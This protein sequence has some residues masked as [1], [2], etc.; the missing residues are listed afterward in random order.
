VTEAGESRGYTARGPVDG[1]SWPAVAAALNA[2]MAER[3]IG[4]KVLSE[5]SGVSVATLRQLQRGTSGRRVQNP[6]L[7]AIARA[8]DWPENHLIDV[9][10]S[11]SASPPAPPVGLFACDPE[12]GDRLAVLDRRMDAL[13][14][15]LADL[16][17]VFDG[18]TRRL[19][20]IG[21]PGTSRHRP[22]PDMTTAPDP[23]G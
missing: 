3:R 14:A 1:E 20:Q 23:E 7:Q 19:D 18:L 11:R 6:T 4:Q 15:H 9:L 2:R 17:E 13:D 8:L 12:I 5:A 22:G 16:R 21:R 10:L